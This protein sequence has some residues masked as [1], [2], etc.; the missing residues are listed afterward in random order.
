VRD[1]E[2]LFV[3]LNNHDYLSSDN[4][5]TNE[6]GLRGAEGNRNRIML[7][8]IPI[9][10]YPIYEY[11]SWLFANYESEYTHIHISVAEREK[12]DCQFGSDLIREITLLRSSM[13]ETVLCLNCSST[14]CAALATS[15]GIAGRV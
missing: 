12:Y 10:S 5:T 3:S 15:K 7:A 14:N 8:S 2:T 11:K 6:L 1:A 4:R 9:T 13:N